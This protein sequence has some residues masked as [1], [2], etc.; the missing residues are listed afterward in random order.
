M[1]VKQKTPGDSG[2]IDTADTKF[3]GRVYVYH[4][5]YLSPEDTVALTQLYKDA[6]LSAIFRSTDY[7]AV[8]KLEAKVKMHNK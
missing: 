1:M 5:T 3:S 6:G 2:T 8:R 7:L 4:E